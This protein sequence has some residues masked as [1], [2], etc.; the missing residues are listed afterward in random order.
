[1]LKNMER[2]PAKHASFFHF[3]PYLKSH[4]SY[5][6]VTRI[7]RK[8]LASLNS[9]PI[10]SPRTCFLLPKSIHLG[11]STPFIDLSAALFAALSLSLQLYLPT[12]TVSAQTARNDN[13]R[14]SRT[15]L[16]D[17]FYFSSAAQSLS[18]SGSGN[19]RGENGSMLERLSGDN[20]NLIYGV[21]TVTS[22]TKTLTVSAGPIQLR[23]PPA[24]SVSFRLTQDSALTIHNMS[25]P[26]TISSATSN[27]ASQSSIN[28]RLTLP[29]GAIEVQSL[30]ARTGDSHSA[31]IFFIG[32]AQFSSEA[33]AKDSAHDTVS[34]SNGQLFFSPP[35]DLKV[36]TPVGV[37]R[38][39]ANSHFFLSLNKE[40]GTARILN[41]SSSELKF[42]A[43]KKF[44]RISS[45]EEFCLYDHRPTQEEVL[46]A[47]GLG[48]K[49]VVMHDIDGQKT[50]STT[51][52]L[53]ASLLTS[54][55]YLGDWK[56]QSTL[57]KKI[58]AGL[59]KSAAAYHSIYASAEEFYI[60]PNSVAPMPNSI[61]PMPNSIAPLP[62]TSNGEIR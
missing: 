23:L 37:L 15:F 46:P 5:D 6:K 52:F 19:L 4:F 11:R 8:R 33:F 55:Y 51:T 16:Y 40:A 42:E 25:A 58:T 53:V 18:T 48:R 20:F 44:R 12:Q 10:F 47:D 3:E 41:C 36:I 34:L 56:R 50:A 21:F 27:G 13:M 38:A 9:L 26:V 2:L 57:D 43:G 22:G 35:R 17:S 49:E 1:M 32:N 39:K 14:T 54:P 31:P 7:N 29:S 28:Q 24:S 59:L 62:N 61:A 45:S 60:A 30:T